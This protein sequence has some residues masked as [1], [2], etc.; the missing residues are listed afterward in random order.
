MNINFEKITEELE[1]TG[2]GGKIIISL[3]FL[4]KK[5]YKGQ[6][7]GAF[8]NYLGGGMLGKVFADTTIEDWRQ[9]EKLVEIAEELKK[10]YFNLTNPPEGCW[11]HQTYEMNQGNIISAY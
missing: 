9:D 7:M 2:R 5:E 11:E 8:Q 3:D 10:Y 1:V 6:K 4:K